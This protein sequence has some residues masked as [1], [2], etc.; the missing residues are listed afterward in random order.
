MDCK[1][2]GAPVQDG[3]GRMGCEMGPS[4]LRT[5]GLAGALRELGHQVADLG[6]ILPAT[7]RPLAHGNLALKALPEISA[8]TAGIAEA[9]YDVSADAMPIFLGGDHS[10]SAGTV[11]GLARRAAEAGR[12]L[13]VLWLDAHPD[14]HTLDTT[15]SGNLHGVPLAYASGQPGFG[16]Y[17]PDLPAAVDPK[18]ICAMGLR[19]VDPAERE[20][21]NQ[22]GVTVHDMRAIDEHGIAPLLRAFLARVAAQDGLLHVSLD[23]DFLDPSIAPAVGTT[24]P[25]GA[26]LREAHLVMEMLSDSGLVSSLDLV[27]LNPFL[28]ERGRTATLMVDLTASLM[29]RRIMD[30]PTLSHSGSF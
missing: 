14:F 25:G 16:G 29:G 22:A 27:E 13:F 7:V 28:D 3:A 4:A 17:F 12:P 15:A 26:T 1:I 8:W 6:T 10:I 11:S 5:A 2:L 20:A 23:V 24:V 30:R 18:R 21:L 9:A 19:S